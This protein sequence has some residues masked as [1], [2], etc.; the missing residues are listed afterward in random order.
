[1]AALGCLAWAVHAS[2]QPVSRRACNAA[3]V[4]WIL[5]MGAGGLG[6]FAVVDAVACRLEGRTREPAGRLR[7][8]VLEALS[9][10]GLAA[11]LL[12]N[13]LTG[14]ANLGLDT[15]A[16]APLPAK[17][18]VGLYLAGVSGA[19]RRLTLARLKGA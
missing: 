3:Y 2:V 18:L 12:A 14:L 5:G 1:M 8:P 11:F 16:V 6:M 9:A 10:Q 13:V 4:A 15:Q 17:L 7:L 19:A